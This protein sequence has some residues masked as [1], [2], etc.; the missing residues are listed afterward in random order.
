MQKITVID[1]EKRQLKISQN[2]TVYEQYRLCV[3]HL[4]QLKSGQDQSNDEE[5]DV[6]SKEKTTAAEGPD[7][8]AA[9]ESKSTPAINETNNYNVKCEEQTT[10]DFIP[11]NDKCL[12]AIV[13]KQDTLMY[14]DTLP[15]YQRSVSC[16]YVSTTGE[17]KQ[18]REKTP[19]DMLVEKQSTQ[20][21]EVIGTVCHLGE[22]SNY[23]KVYFILRLC[24]SFMAKGSAGVKSQKSKEESRTFL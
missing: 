5:Y 24:S 21:N 7:Q 3:D 8:P 4:H 6:Q 10:A 23:A 2:L 14:S 17:E 18:T 11:R 9:P 20:D 13:E 19:R 12:A 1:P 22:K 16:Y 15:K